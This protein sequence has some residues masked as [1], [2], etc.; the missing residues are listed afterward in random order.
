MRLLNISAFTI[1]LFII[2]ILSGFTNP[3]SNNPPVPGT[4][5]ELFKKE[6]K[7]PAK[8][9]GTIPFFVWNGEITKT[10]IDEKMQEDFSSLFTV[11][12]RF[13]QKIIAKLFGKT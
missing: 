2:L 10:G 7:T 9:Y 6:F 1:A 12:I 5:F 11:I 8:E 13:F 3:K 4:K